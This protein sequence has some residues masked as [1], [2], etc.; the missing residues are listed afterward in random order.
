M[1][2]YVSITLID[3]MIELKKNLAVTSE[4][5]MQEALNS[6]NDEEKEVLLRLYVEDSRKM[7]IDIVWVKV[8]HIVQ[9]KNIWIGW[10]K[11]E[12]KLTTATCMESNSF[13]IMI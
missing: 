2:K 8:A 3:E 7:K 10:K 12:H 11:L 1:D 13:K 9:I 4:N 5:N 6:L